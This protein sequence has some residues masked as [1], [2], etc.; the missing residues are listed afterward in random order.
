MAEHCCLSLVSCSRFTTAG[1][2]VDGKDLS[3]T[4]KEILGMYVS[5]GCTMNGKFLKDLQTEITNQGEVEVPL[6]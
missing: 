5:V 1:C 4:I 2:T 3:G 6:E